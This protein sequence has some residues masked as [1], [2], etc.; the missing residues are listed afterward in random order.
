MI[1]EAQ[2]KRLVQAVADLEEEMSRFLSEAVR[3]PSVSGYEGKVADWYAEW[4]RTRG[5]E[6]E[7]QP[8][9]ES[10]LAAEESLVD[11][12]ENLIAF[13]F[14]R[15]SANDKVIVLNGHI[16][17][18][19][20]GDEENWDHPPFSGE[21]RHGRVHG[22]G[23]V[24]MKGGI[25]A[26]VF[27][28]LALLDTGATLS[29][30]PVLQL[31]IGEETGG[32]GTRLALSEYGPPDAAIVMEPTNNALVHI[33]TG[34]QF[35][36]VETF[37]RA[38]HSSAPWLG[39]DALQRLVSLR[40]AMI[41]T[42]DQRSTLFAHPRY[43]DI[44]TP[45]PFNIGQFSAGNY[46]AAVPDHGR[47]IGRIGL[48]PLEKASDARTEY[49]E[50]LR[51]RSAADGFDYEDSYRLTWLGREFPAWATAESSSLVTSFMT[52]LEHV[53]TTATLRG[54]TAGSDA[55]QYGA[56]GVPTVIFGPGDLSLAH[57]AQECVLE[58]DVTRAAQTLALALASWS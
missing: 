26:G 38:A 25:T 56:L 57:T 4:L 34:L 6:F 10:S 35:F 55:G 8:L 17:V 54:L 12:R 45:I 13:P 3:I 42:A 31:V 29:A 28:L 23:S 19:P 32:V 14:G 24:D 22:R 1:E 36:E 43:A 40:Q 9:R 49:E 18:V 51:Q 7:R 11:Q 47:M 33:C 41:D 30:T 15:P 37:G 46:Q 53:D 58:N 27:A 48:H 2:T 16:D 50:A 21:R 20:P 39:V 5:W 52:A 44:P